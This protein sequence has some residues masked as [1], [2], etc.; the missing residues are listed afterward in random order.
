MK[1]SKLLLLAIFALCLIVSEAHSM[2]RGP[3]PHPHHHH[4]EIESGSEEHPHPHFPPH[5]HHHHEEENDIDEHPHPHP[6]I[7]LFEGEKK[8][9]REIKIMKE[10]RMPVERVRDL[11]KRRAAEK[12]FKRAKKMS[13]R[14]DI[15]EVA[16]TIYRDSECKYY[17][18]DNIRRVGCS[19]PAFGKFE[20]IEF[21]E[22]NEDN[23]TIYTYSTPGCNSNPVY[24]RSF[25]KEECKKDPLSGEYIKWEW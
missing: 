24:V 4:H 21:D 15:E 14:G 20:K 18:D 11:H 22:A 2:R 23:M 17:Y 5:H 8:D 19:M 9:F 12:L 10:A 25:V 7:S 16:Y 3:R 13:R 6:K 1:F